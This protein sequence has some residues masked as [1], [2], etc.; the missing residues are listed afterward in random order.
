[1][2]KET[3]E[4]NDSQNVEQ[5][6]ENST[7][8][9]EEEE[10]NTEGEEESKEKPEYSENEKKLYA[11]AKK[12]EE[13]LKKL[14]SETP[15]KK[16]SSDDVI[17]TRLEVRGVMEKEDQDYVLRFAK[18][19]GKNPLDVLNDDIVKD[20]LEANKR[21]RDSAKATPRSNNRT[22]NKEDEVAMWVRKYKNDGSLPDNNPALTS[23]ILSK[24]REEE[25]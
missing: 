17:L 7:N 18:A 12:A 23:K 24:L 4:N 10:S 5:E 25:A 6:N 2:E 15:E 13:E 3:N 8:E 20:R 19:E 14:K 9:N 1:M 22:N 21:K 11:R 16:D